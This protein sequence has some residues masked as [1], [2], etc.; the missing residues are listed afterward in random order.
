MF[1][2]PNLPHAYLSGDC[3]ECMACS[4][5]VVRAGLTPKLIDVPTLC[6]MLIYQCPDDDK[7][8]ETFKFKAVPDSDNSAVYN[9]PVPDFSFSKLTAKKGAAKVCFPIRQILSIRHVEIPRVHY[10]SCQITICRSYFSHLTV[11]SNMGIGFFLVAVFWNSSTNH[12]IAIPISKH[13]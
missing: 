9:A 11:F 7:V 5:N 10:F 4:D 1:L 3:I 6:E 12:V 2:G 13:S 8:E